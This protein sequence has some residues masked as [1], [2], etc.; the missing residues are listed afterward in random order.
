MLPLSYIWFWS[1]SSSVV[2]CIFA[3][4]TPFLLLGH[5]GVSQ[6]C[7]ALCNP[8]DCSLPGSSVHGILKARILEW[9]AFPFPEVLPWMKVKEESEKAGLYWMLGAG[10][11]GWPR[12]MVRG[13]RWEEGSGRGTRVYLWQ[14]H[15]DIWQNQYNIVKLKKKKLRSWYPVPSLH[16]KQMWKK[17]GN[18]DRLYFFWLQSHCGLWLQPWN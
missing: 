17:N 4:T 12:G 9:V 7:L 16:G 3:R 1:L 8:I 14:I 2:L 15:V 10:A 18:S 11:L 5:H 6:S 13:W